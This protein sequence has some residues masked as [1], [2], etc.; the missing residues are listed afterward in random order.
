MRGEEA[1]Q[2]DADQTYSF[3]DDF[4]GEDVRSSSLYES[5]QEAEHDI[6]TAEHNIHASISVNNTLH[7]K[8]MNLL[9]LSE[10]YHISI[11]YGG[12]DT[13]VLEKGSIYPQLKKSK[14][15]WLLS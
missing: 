5:G 10:K 9:F 13:C 7:N 14:L 12:A 6:W 15:G 8:C 11:L 3:V 1:V 2:E 4:F